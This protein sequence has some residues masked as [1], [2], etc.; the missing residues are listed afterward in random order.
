MNIAKCGKRAIA[1]ARPLNE[2]KRAR[3]A[4][5]THAAG[6]VI[7]YPDTSNQNTA[8]AGRAWE[9]PTKAA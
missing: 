2:K 5:A 1:R 7:R 4:A 8:T 9:T 3:S 6:L